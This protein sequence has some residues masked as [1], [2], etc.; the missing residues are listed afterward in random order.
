VDCVG[1]GRTEKEEDDE[2]GMRGMGILYAGCGFG[3]G[4][5]EVSMSVGQEEDRSPETGKKI[6]KRGRVSRVYQLYTRPKGGVVL[7]ISRR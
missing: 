6:Q 2:C 5:G 4:G 3:G 7:K 1:F